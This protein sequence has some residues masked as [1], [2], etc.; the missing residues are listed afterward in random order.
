ML[1]MHLMNDKASS[2]ELDAIWNTT[3]TQTNIP[4]P[5]AIHKQRTDLVPSV[6][7]ICRSIQQQ[8]SKRLLRV[9]WDSGGSHSLIHSRVLPKGATPVV[10]PNI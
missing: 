9:L 3:Y 7:M 6:L 10:L 1:D 2:D 5:K 4:V 8:E